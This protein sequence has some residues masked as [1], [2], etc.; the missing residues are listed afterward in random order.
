MAE[1]NYS[2]HTTAANAPAKRHDITKRWIADVK[3]QTKPD[4]QT[5]NKR[6]RN[7]WPIVTCNRMKTENIFVGYH[8]D[9]GTECAMA[10]H[11]LRKINVEKASDAILLN[12]HC[13]TTAATTKSA[14]VKLLVTFFL[15]PKKFL[16]WVS[17]FQ[18]LACQFYNHCTMGSLAQLSAQ[19]TSKLI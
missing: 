14:R 3:E 4:M 18:W 2:D 15:P 10:L 12:K 16:V 5:R 8:P 13:E 7:K 6:T 19:R 9:G 17:I 11:I 1:H